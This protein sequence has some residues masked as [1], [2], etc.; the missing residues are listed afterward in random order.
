[1]KLKGKGSVNTPWRNGFSRKVKPKGLIDQ[2]VEV[3][4][5]AAEATVGEGII[6]KGERLVREENYG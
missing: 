2:D 3:P 1:V 4:F 5:Q 6:P